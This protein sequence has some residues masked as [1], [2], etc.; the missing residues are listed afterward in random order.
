MLRKATF[1]VLLEVCY[2]VQRV[3]LKSVEDLRLREESAEFEIFDK[4]D[5]IGKWMAVLKGVSQRTNLRGIGWG[6][7]DGLKLGYFTNKAK[8]VVQSSINRSERAT[9]QRTVKGKKR[10]LESL[11]RTER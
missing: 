4:T 11:H 7:V 5:I 10:T 2:L 3:S 1:H 6:T 8:E 9:T